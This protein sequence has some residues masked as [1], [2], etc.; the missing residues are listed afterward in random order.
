MAKSS[1]SRPL[2]SFTI[3]MKVE[4]RQAAFE[5]FRSQGMLD[6]ERLS[7]GN[8]KVEV[9]I[10]KDGCCPHVI[11][12]VI[13]NGMVVGS[14]AAPC[15]E[16]VGTKPPRELLALAKK[17]TMEITA[18]NKWKPVPVARFFSSISLARNLFD[19]YFCTWTDL[20]NAWLVCC[21]LPSFRCNIVD[22]IYRGPLRF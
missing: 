11:S 19:Q 6:I 10:I 9:G 18:R 4:I 1:K 21:V 8:H 22:R 17:A 12:A 14:E 20:G 2:A 5:L 7:R 13:K 15:K 3:P 16:S